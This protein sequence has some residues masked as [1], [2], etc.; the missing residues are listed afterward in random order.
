[1]TTNKTPF[2]LCWQYKGGTS[3]RETRAFVSAAEAREY[4][5]RQTRLG[6]HFVSAYD[7]DAVR[8]RRSVA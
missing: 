8:K 5:E 6:E 7:L 2:R 4:G 3:R 1:M